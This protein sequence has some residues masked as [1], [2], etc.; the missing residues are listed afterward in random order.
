MFFEKAIESNWL[1]KMD[2]RMVT[3]FLML[4]HDNLF[5]VPMDLRS[6]ADK[7]VAKLVR[8]VGKFY[9]SSAFRSVFDTS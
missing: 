2:G 1:L 3:V 9:L 4:I 6:I 8:E 7:T 5:E